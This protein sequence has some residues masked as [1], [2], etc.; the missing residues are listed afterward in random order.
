MFCLPVLIRA[1]PLLAVPPSDRTSSPRGLLCLPVYLVVEGFLEG[2]ETVFSALP[3]APRVSQS[4]EA[5]NS[6][7]SAILRKRACPHESLLDCPAL[8]LALYADRVPNR[9]LKQGDA[10][11]SLSAYWAHATLNT[12][13]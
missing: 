7:G 2:G 8:H 12:V 5:G 1:L 10:G 6:A 4:V 13:R 9:G 11:D 3:R